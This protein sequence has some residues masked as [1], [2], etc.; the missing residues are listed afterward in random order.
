MNNSR[1]GFTLAEV[2]VTLA[3]IGVVAALTIP[4][5]IQNTNSQRYQTAFKKNLSILNQAILTAAA[6]SSTAPTSATSGPTLADFFEASLNTLKQNGS[7]LWLADGSKIEFSYTG[8]CAAIATPSSVANP[9]ASGCAA[10]I[11]VNGD[12]GPNTSSTPSNVSDVYVVGITSNSVVPL[13]GVTTALS[14]GVDNANFIKDV[15][16]TVIAAP[17]VPYVLT[18][19]AVGNAAINA[20]TGG[21]T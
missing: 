12:K 7:T 11:D 8:T 21:S 15:N 3:I 14:S 4:T 20:I 10:V 17:G 6:N 1:K 18:S 19:T 16:G 9:F 13:G 2:L 5:L